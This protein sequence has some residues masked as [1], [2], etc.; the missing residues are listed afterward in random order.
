MITQELARQIVK[1]ELGLSIVNLELPDEVIDRN[2]AR[3]LMTMGAYYSEPSYATVTITRGQS[4]NNSSGRS[5][6]GYVE[7]TDIDP[8]GVSVIIAVYP[9]TNVMRADAALLGLGSMY[10]NMGQALASQI[11]AY[12]NMINNLTNLE[13][14]LGRNA[15][16][17]GDKL[18]VD[19]Y[20]GDI[21]VA[22][23]PK[24]LSIENI[25][26]GDWLRWVLEYT[27]ALSK[28]Q[29]AQTRGKYI[30]TSNPTT[31]NAE[32]LLNNAN[33][34]LEKLTEELKTKGVITASR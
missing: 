33:E 16:I 6:G 7:L 11:N 1:D 2:I 27:I 22:Y 20:Y 23:I 29:L 21:T 31:T 14:I 5:S 32:T 9:T 19:H 10:F 8:L 3:A 18:F 26:D 28:R 15:R 13:S 30:V 24:V 17:V 12:S 34:Q 4:G 25:S